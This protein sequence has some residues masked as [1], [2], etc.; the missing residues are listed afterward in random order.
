MDAD[1]RRD[2]PNREESAVHVRNGATPRIVT[3]RQLLIWHPEDDLRADDEPGH[4]NR[5]DLRPRERCTASFDGSNRLLD[6]DSRRGRAHSSKSSGELP[7]RTARRIYL[8]VARV[9][10]DL[11][12]RNERRRHFRKTLEQD[13]SQSEVAAGKHT[14][15]LP[16]CD[17]ID[18]SKINVRETRRADDDMGTTVER[19]KDVRLGRIWF[20]V[21]DEDI[22]I[23]RERL[24]GRGGDTRRNARLVN[25]IAKH[26]SGM[27]PA[28]RR[29]ECEIR[30]PRNPARQLGPSP[31]GR[32]GETHSDH[33][34]SS[35]REDYNRG[36]R[37]F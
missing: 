17:C 12:L 35:I 26:L 21:L 4:A 13:D 27:S 29:H 2:S 30:R 16:A 23:G 37:V 33:D 19:S 31:T 28:Y 22:A 10:D 6:R 11:P 24:G 36:D 1:Q 14:T 8:G 5:M 32:T 7:S 34:V 9:V 3:D 15:V 25:D 18:I 20:R